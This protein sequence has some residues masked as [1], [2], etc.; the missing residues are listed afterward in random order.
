MFRNI[1]YSVDA[2]VF[3]TLL[4]NEG[5]TD[6]D[7]DV[8]TVD[9]TQMIMNFTGATG[10][11]GTWLTGDTDDD[12]DVDTVDLTAAIMNYTGVLNAA[13]TVVPEPSCL[14]LLVMAI[15]CLSVTRAKNYRH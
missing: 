6:G 9:L 15:G 10:S 7:R 14:L 2:V 1:T 4:A 13:V 3:E 12:D 5:D 11:G 8:D